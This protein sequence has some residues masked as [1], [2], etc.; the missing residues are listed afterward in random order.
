M[1]I[2]LNNITSGFN[3]AKINANFQNIED[4][5]NDKLLAREATGVSGE[6]MMERALDMNSNRILNLPAPLYP[7]DPIRFQ[8]LETLAG[9]QDDEGAAKL[10]LELASSPLGDSL[11]AVQQ[12]STGIVRT[13]HDKNL[14]IKSLKDFGA[15]GDGTTLDTAAISVAFTWLSGAA[16]RALY[17]PDGVYLTGAVT[18][19]FSG[20][21]TTFCKIYGPGRFKHANTTGDMITITEAMYCSFELNISGDGYSASTIADYSQAD[22]VNVQ[23]AVVFNSNRACSLS[24]KAFGYPGRVLRT[25][26][27]GTLKMSFLE[28][29]IVTGNDTCGQAMYLQGGADAYGCIKYANTNWDY[30]GSV[31]DSITDFSIVYMEAGAKGAGNPALTLSSVVNAHIGILAIGQNRT[32]SALLV[33]GG[34]AITIQKALLGESTYGLEV[35]GTGTA[36]PYPQLTIHSL[37]VANVDT[38]AVRFS[39]VVNARILDYTFDGTPYG[40][41]YFN[42][43]RDI[44]TSGHCR[45][46]SIAA[47]YGYLASTLESVKIGGKMYT[48]GSSTFCDFTESSTDNVLLEDTTA[49]TTGYYLKLKDGSNG[50]NV[51]GGK[52][53]GSTLV[54]SSPINN[55][56]QTIRQVSGIATRATARTA[57]FLSGAASG[58]QTTIAHGLYNTPSEVFVTVT[59]PSNLVTAGNSTVLLVSKDSTNLVFKYS[60]GSTLTSALNFTFTAKSEERAN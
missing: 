49:V 53:T 42:L 26:S 7:T 47:H 39:N 10:R 32:N 48:A 45:N 29:S 18:A 2:V 17:V 9:Y 28:L 12:P 30:Y 4:Y 52:W 13:Q 25:K 3:L 21:A 36:Q 19:T 43:A 5:I 44:E 46:P 6:A 14:D 35:I 24:I 58:T 57:S 31:V 34:R 54:G 22:P 8:D 40:I 11:I 50:V 20:A 16:G 33:N 23:Q 60:G 55:R 51:R 37:Y 1:A 56:P 15:I 59:D 38:A 27:T 41:M